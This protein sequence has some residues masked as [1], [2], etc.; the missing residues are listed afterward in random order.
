MCESGTWFK[1]FK[2]TTADG[3]DPTMPRNHV[4]TEPMTKSRGNGID[5]VPIPL[6]CAGNTM[7]VKPACDVTVNT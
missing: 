5:D 7:M 4:A 3:L 2:I 1:S 6:R